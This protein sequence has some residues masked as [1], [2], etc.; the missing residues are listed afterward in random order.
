M[1]DTSIIQRLTTHINGGLLMK[2]FQRSELVLI[3][4]LLIL[5]IF[6]ANSESYAWSCPQCG[7][8]GN[9]GNYCGGCAHPAPWLFSIPSV[10]PVLNSMPTTAPVP[11]LYKPGSNSVLT[12]I[13]LGYA[14]HGKIIWTEE[15]QVYTGEQWIEGNLA[16]HS[17]VFMGEDNNYWNKTNNNNLRYD[18]NKS[19]NGYKDSKLKPYF[20]TWNVSDS[21]KASIKMNVKTKMEN[22]RGTNVIFNVKFTGNTIPA[23]ISKS[24]FQYRNLPGGNS[25]YK[26]IYGVKGQTINIYAKKK[27]ADNQWWVLFDADLFL[28]T[29]ST[30]TDPNQKPVNGKIESWWTPVNQCLDTSSFNLDSI[31]LYDD[32]MTK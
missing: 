8:T 14:C 10:T 24:K 13:T 11:T 12:T 23:V 15:R 30:E 19:Q 28:R 17:Y 7:R 9:T 25:T 3:V 4:F 22:E 26:V 6:S 29:E 27:D 2:R 20:I 16:N 5:T 1:I 18:D 21:Q 32:I 31:P